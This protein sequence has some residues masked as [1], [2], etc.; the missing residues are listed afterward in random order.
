MEIFFCLNK[1]EIKSKLNEIFTIFFSRKFPLIFHPQMNSLCSCQHAKQM[2]E[3]KCKKLFINS[4][5]FQPNKRSPSKTLLSS[6]TMF[7]NLLAK[8]YLKN[9][10]KMMSQFSFLFIVLHFL[11]KLLITLQVVEW[12]R[13]FPFF[14]QIEI[15]IDSACFARIEKIDLVCSIG[16]ILIELDFNVI[17]TIWV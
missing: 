6:S 8:S 3:G 12:S 5:I 10:L 7:N 14:L 16:F 17:V 15:L 11:I 4:S 2:N 1:R 13:I 9:I